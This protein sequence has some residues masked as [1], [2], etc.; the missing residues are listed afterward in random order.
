MMEHIFS[1]L[2]FSLTS[3]RTS[4]QNNHNRAHTLLFASLQQEGP[5]NMREHIHSSSLTLLHGL[6][7]TYFEQSAEHHEGSTSNLWTIGVWEITLS[8]FI[9]PSKPT[10][11]RRNKLDIFNFC[12]DFSILIPVLTTASQLCFDFGVLIPALSFTT[13]SSPPATYSTRIP[14]VSSCQ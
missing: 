13:V 11:P 2:A 9:F 12:F 6:C 4:Q 8:S 3:C 10:D 1:L 14:F 7:L 5:V